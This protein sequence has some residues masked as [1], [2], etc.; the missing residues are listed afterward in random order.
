MESTHVQPPSPFCFFFIKA[1]A[2]NANRTMK[3]NSIN[4]HFVKKISI[5][6]GI[7]ARQLKKLTPNAATNALK[8]TDEL[9]YFFEGG[10]FI[11]VA[12]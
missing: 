8:V 6:F 10:Y 9:A 5:S 4:I 12:A 11:T 1:H 2:A 7:L 3:C